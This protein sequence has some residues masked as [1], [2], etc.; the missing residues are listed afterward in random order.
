MDAWIIG[1]QIKRYL[2]TNLTPE[3]PYDDTDTWVDTY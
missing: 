3:V 1:E 2:V